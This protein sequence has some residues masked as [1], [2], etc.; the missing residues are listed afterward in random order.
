MDRS[1]LQAMKSSIESITALPTVPANLKRI[2]IMMEKPRLTLDELARFIS[3]DPALA[4]KVLTMVN[5]A[6]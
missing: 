5:S 1:N 6:A 2:A 3:H 4:T